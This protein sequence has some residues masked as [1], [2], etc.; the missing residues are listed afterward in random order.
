MPLNEDLNDF[1]LSN[2]PN[3]DSQSKNKKFYLDN[4]DSKLDLS[5]PNQHK[6]NTSNKISKFIRTFKKKLRITSTENISKSNSNINEHDLSIQSNSS[7]KSHTKSSSQKQTKQNRDI[8]GKLFKAY[9]RTFRKDLVTKIDSA[10]SHSS[11]NSYNNKQQMSS[12][13]ISD[14]FPYQETTNKYRK[15][16]KNDPNLFD[17]NMNLILSQV[18]DKFGRDSPLTRQ[19]YDNNYYLNNKSNDIQVRLR[20]K[21]IQK[22]DS[23][24]NYSKYNGSKFTRSDESINKYSQIQ[25]EILNDSVLIPSSASKNND[26]TQSLSRSKS[27]NNTAQTPTSKKRVSFHEQVLKTDV[28]SG[29]SELVPIFYEM[30]DKVQRISTQQ[31][32]NNDDQQKRQQQQKLNIPFRVDTTNRNQLN[33]SQN[34][35]LLGPFYEIPIRINR[36]NLAPTEIS[37]PLSNA[38]QYEMINFNTNQNYSAYDNF[39]TNKTK[40]T[41][42]HI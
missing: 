15:S 41:I 38:G 21:Q 2:E 23:A 29:N 12:T 19:T 30:K 40:T 34:T 17:Y 42:E 36:V 25:N 4:D 5:L 16:N 3:F 10:S 8:I 31:S 1:T 13:N 37:Y 22:P 7:Y 35:N 39:D 20:D 24:E 14:S 26:L 11:L 18:N 28:E 33:L 32:N 6:S 27:L 9:N